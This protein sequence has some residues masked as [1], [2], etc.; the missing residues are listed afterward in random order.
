MRVFKYE[1]SLEGLT[2][3][4]IQLKLGRNCRSLIFCF[5]AFSRNLPTYL[6]SFFFFQPY[7]GII[8][9]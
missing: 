8:D 4:D 9:N 6:D 7:L 2:K 1:K 5:Y 3:E